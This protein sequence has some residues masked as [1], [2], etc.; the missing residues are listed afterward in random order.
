MRS[1]RGLARDLIATARMLWD[2]Y[3]RRSRIWDRLRR[4][5]DH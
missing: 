1:R 5:R 2:A 4:D 3:A